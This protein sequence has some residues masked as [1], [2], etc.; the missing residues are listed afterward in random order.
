MEWSRFIRDMR[1]YS[2]TNVSGEQLYKNRRPTA[3]LAFL[4]STSAQCNPRVRVFLR[5]T[6]SGASEFVTYRLVPLCRGIL[7]RVS[8]PESG[9]IIADTG[10][11]RER[12]GVNVSEQKAPGTMMMTP[13]A[14]RFSYNPYLHPGEKLAVE[15]DTTNVHGFNYCI[16]DAIQTK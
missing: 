3:R 1:T 13:S 9:L 14:A 11:I 4:I 2:G 5:P 8:E 6:F 16:K 15:V 10:Y 12:H 7:T